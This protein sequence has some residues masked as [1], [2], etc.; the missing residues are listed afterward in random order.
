MASPRFGTSWNF[1][2][3]VLVARRSSG[4]WHRTIA[5]EIAFGGFA[6][7]DVSGDGGAEIRSGDFHFRDFLIEAID[8]EDLVEL[9]HAAVLEIDHDEAQGGAVSDNATAEEIDGAD[10]GFV[11]SRVIAD[12]F[13]GDGAGGF[14]SGG[15]GT[16]RAGAFATGSAPDESGNEYREQIRHRAG[17][18]HRRLVQ[19]Q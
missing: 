5:H 10:G 2:A 18:I 15:D 6:G 7:D 9:G 17:L 19:R 8:V 4:E 1:S 3:C 13:R 14:G 11:S 12:G 16:R